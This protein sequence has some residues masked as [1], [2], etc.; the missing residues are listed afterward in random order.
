[1]QTIYDEARLRSVLFDFYNATGISIQLIYPD[2][3]KFGDSVGIHNRYCHA[4][5]QTM[6]GEQA[7]IRSDDILLQK[8]R[9]TKQMQMHVCHAGLIDIA[10]PIIYEDEILAYIIL[11]QLKSET[12]FSAAR[13]LIAA[14][15][16]DLAEMEACYAT[17]TLYDKERI[18]SVANIA[19]MLAKYVLLEHLLKPNYNNATDR[20]IA[21]I[22]AHL[23]QPLS[24]RQISD[25]VNVS[26]SVLYK[27]FHAIFHC[28]L[29]DYVNARRIDRAATLLR[30]TPLSV[31]E[32]SQR[33]GFSSAAYFSKVFKEQKGISP[34][35]FRNA[36]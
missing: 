11:G 22:N 5:Q 15:P 9:E 31:E 24:I 35:K 27:N 32:I 30:S 23:E 8:C 2:F 34:L 3:S 26:K 14:F 1:M 36:K 17:L 4:I 12:N 13:K 19:S 33:V 6:C 7:C 29:G 28:T 16:V 20:A 18:N 25:A 10:V 21:Y